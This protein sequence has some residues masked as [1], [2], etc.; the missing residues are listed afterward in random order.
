MI[1]VGNKMSTIFLF[2]LLLCTLGAVYF[3]SEKGAYVKTDSGSFSCVLS[4]IFSIGAMLSL[5]L[6]F[7]FVI[8]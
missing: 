4:I 8:I 1:K 3:G 6:T 2:L 7:V 5:I